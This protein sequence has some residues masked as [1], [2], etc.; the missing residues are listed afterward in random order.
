MIKKNLKNL[1]SNIALTKRNSLA[2]VS[3][4]IAGSAYFFLPASCPQAARRM[5]FIFVIAAF[6]WA[7]EI[8]PLHATS[9]FVILL[10]ILLLTKR[11]GT[12]LDYQVFLIPFSNPIIFLFLGGFTLAAALHKYQLDRELAERLLSIFGKNP[13]WVMLGF[14]MTTAFFAFWMSATATTAMMLILIAP[15]LSQT[16]AD[17]PFRKALVLSIPFGARIGGLCTPIGT[18]PNAIAVGILQEQGIHLSF[19]S[20]MAMGVPLAFIILVVSSLV[21]YGLFRPHQEEM[22][23]VFPKE[24]PVEA[25]GKIVFAIGLLTVGLW[26][27][28]GLHKIPEAVVSLLAVALFFGLN[29]LDRHDL[30]R[31]DWDILILM[32]GG[33]ALGEGMELSGLTTW[34]VGSP[35]FAQS[36]IYLLAALCLLAMGIST[37]MSNTAAAN[38]LIP[39]AVSIPG[40]NPVFLAVAVALSCSF[41]VPLPISSPPNAMAFSTGVVSVKDMLKAGIPIT[42]VAIT[43]IIF[44]SRF[45]M[46][47][48]FGL[49]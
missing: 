45:I 14:M 33:L 23:F 25:K 29:L 27:T 2:A 39:L 41:D 18:P 4:V 28:S 13:F 42:L 46:G 16:E 21:L 34:I 35:L 32:W 37:F 15:L 43:L 1:F 31:I 47:I 22:S 12:D 10:E 38:L 48:V 6:F 24:E 17:D 8:V 5:A 44:G 49:K 20:W 30:K 40:E 11:G 19:L 36:G 3:L 7:F 26:L 9:F